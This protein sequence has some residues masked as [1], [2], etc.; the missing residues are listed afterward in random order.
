MPR[1]YF[2]LMKVNGSVRLLPAAKARAI[3]KSL[4]VTLAS[5]TNTRSYCSLLE[6]LIGEGATLSNAAGFAM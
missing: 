4:P 3:L 5:L 1:I 2:C 6:N